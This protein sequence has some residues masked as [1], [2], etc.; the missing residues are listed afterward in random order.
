MAEFWGKAEERVSFEAGVRLHHS[1]WNLVAADSRVTAEA[2]QGWTRVTIPFR[3]SAELPPGGEVRAP[4]LFLG[5]LG[6]GTVLWLAGAGLWELAPPTPLV[7]PRFS[8]E[9]LADPGFEGETLRWKGQA[10]DLSVT[11]GTG[12]GGSRACLVRR[13][14]ARWG[15]PVQSIRAALCEAGCTVYRFGAAVRRTDGHGE[16]IVVIHLRDRNG[17]RWIASSKRHIGHRGF[18]RLR[19]Q[20]LI[21]W[22]GDLLEA[23]ISVQ[24]IG[25][26][27]GDLCVDDLSLRSADDLA[28][29]RAYSASRQAEGHNA[30]LA[31]D[32]D[33]TTSWRD[34]LPG[35]GWLEVDFG[36]IVAL[37][38]CVLAVGR[39]HAGAYEIQ[40]WDGRWQTAFAG[41]DIGPPLDELRFAAV[42]GRKARIR[43]EGGPRPTEVAE[44]RFYAYPDPP[45]RTSDRTLVAPPPADPAR[46]GPKTLVGAIRWDGWCGDRHPVGVQLERVMAPARYHERLPFYASVRESGDIQVRCVTQDTMDREI[47]FAAKAGIDYWAFDW[48]APG[49]GLALARDL[50]L[51]STQRNAVKWCVILTPQPFTTADCSWLIEQFHTPNYQCVLNGRPLVYVFQAAKTHRN[52]VQSL[53]RDTVQAGLATPFIVFMGW[54]AAIAETA[55]ACGADALGAYVTPLDGGRTFA[56]CMAHERERWQQ[57]RATGCQVVPTVTTGWDPRPFVHT[58]VPWYKGA[59]PDNWVERGTPEEIAAQ[60]RAGLDFVAEHPEATLANSLLIYAWN[61]NAEGGWIVPTR[62]ELNERRCPLRLDAVRSV[63][64]PSASRGEGWETLVD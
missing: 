6:A 15:S 32:G 63:L 57:L 11:E 54:S 59:S 8:G 12:V 56:A 34:T 41:N 49:T 24:T 31:F 25:N 51:A 16:A 44:L 40:V 26:D 60:L 2:G 27:M 45:P 36:D 17:D 23:E 30:A 9:L 43:F 39:R 47:A 48:Y 61:E 1:P 4:G 37:N 64:R 18:A 7:S 14:T 20:R 46:R 19:E 29:G 21:H 53:R 28:H 52:L 55:E 10:A 35:T 22:D 42:R 38:G 13:R 5:H 62:H 3:V 33:M 50:Y 58:P